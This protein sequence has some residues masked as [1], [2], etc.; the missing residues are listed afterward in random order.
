MGKNSV[1]PSGIVHVLETDAGRKL[2]A[3]NH[4]GPRWPTMQ[5]A[6]VTSVSGLSG[7]GIEV[8][9]CQ[10]W[11]VSAQNDSCESSAAGA[12]AEATM[13]AAAIYA[14]TF[15]IML[16]TFAPRVVGIQGVVIANLPFSRFAPVSL[17]G[18][19]SKLPVPFAPA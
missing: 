13:S 16:M 15:F 12:G 5:F 6:P 3:R 1:V 4:T 2:V 18:T 8:P 7:S 11:A 14:S 10:Y 9:H 17:L 19:P